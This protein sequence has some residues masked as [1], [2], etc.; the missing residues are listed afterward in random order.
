MQELGYC[1]WIL[2]VEF[3][4]WGRGLGFDMNFLNA[5]RHFG[6]SVVADIDTVCVLR[7]NCGG[8]LNFVK[9]LPKSCGTHPL[10]P[11]LFGILKKA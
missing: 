3:V 5:S 11:C 6:F 1:A 2:R 10:P 4:F 8:S 9:T 7:R